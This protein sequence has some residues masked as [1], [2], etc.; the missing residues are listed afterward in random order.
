M[1]AL[2]AALVAQGVGVAL[3]PLAIVVLLALLGTRS[4]RRN[5]PAFL[6]G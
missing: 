3:S 2:L 1:T 4:A 6:A 5:G